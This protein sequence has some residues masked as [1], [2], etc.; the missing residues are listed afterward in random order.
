MDQNQ[1]IAFKWS[2][3]KDKTGVEGGYV[4]N[5]KD[6]GKATKHGITYDTSREYPHLWAK[7]NWDGDMRTLPISLA[8]EIYDIG[9]WARMKLDDVAQLS[10]EL[11]EKLFDFGIN[12]GRTN[13]VYSLQR[14]LNVC[15]RGG[16]LYPNIKPDGGLGDQVLGALRAYLKTNGPDADIQ[17]AYNLGCMQVSYYV[18]ISEKRANEA[19]EEFTRGWLNRCW[20]DAKLFA[21]RHLKA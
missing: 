3:I 8:Y 14:L 13:A 9:W 16:I 15:N 5:P 19:N 11:A 10:S 12:A 18:E 21:A 7:H 17:I 20:R 6:L 4:D 1:L 2:V